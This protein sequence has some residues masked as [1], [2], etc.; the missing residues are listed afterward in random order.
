MT[1]DPLDALRLPVVPVEPRPQFAAALLRRIDTAGEEPPARAARRTVTVRYFVDDLAAAVAFYCQLLGFSEE[2]R[3]APAFAM[4]HRGDLRLLL[5][6]PGLA[7]AGRALPDGAVPEPGGWN[8][9]AL[10]VEDLA[11][12][13][14]TLRGAGARFRGEVVAG[15]GV[16][17]ILLQDP[18]G[19]LVE[20]FEPDRENRT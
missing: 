20:L 18:S 19:N 12:T 11:S 13:V 1:T 7:G 14:A 9:I 16:R 15:V 8:R 10:P 3:A 4:L 6:V 5:S 2:V 17:Q